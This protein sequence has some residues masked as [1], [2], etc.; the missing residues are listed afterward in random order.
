MVGNSAVSLSDVSDGASQ[1]YLYGEK[2][3]DPIDYETGRGV[4]DVHSLYHCVSSSCVRYAKRSPLRDAAGVGCFACH[5]FG[6]AQ[7][8]GW[9][10]ALCDGSV[11][12]RRYGADF[13]VHQA[14]ASRDWGDR[15]D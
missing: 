1:T 2:A 12:L 13:P 11:Q 10:A 5:D 7:R 9:L 8:D 3:M 15:T 6:S 14:L 4:G